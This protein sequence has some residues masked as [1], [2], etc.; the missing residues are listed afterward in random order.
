[1][2]GCRGAVLSTDQSSQGSRLATGTPL[3]AGTGAPAEGRADQQ[4]LP[5]WEGRS[6]ETLHT[7]VLRGGRTDFPA[8]PGRAPGV[9]DLGG[10]ISFT[11]TEIT[12]CNTDRPLGCPPLYRTD[13]GSQHYGG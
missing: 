2:R 8:G 7:A 13:P 9:R 5:H 10:E 1:M 11:S 12:G 3:L 4:P 6:S